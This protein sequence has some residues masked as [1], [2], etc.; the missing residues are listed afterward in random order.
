MARSAGSTFDGSLPV[1][2]KYHVGAINWGFVAGKTQ[3]W[4]PWD[5]WDHPY[6]R[7]QPVLW[8]HEVFRQ[9]DT[10]YRQAEVDLIRRLTQSSQSAPSPAATPSLPASPSAAPGTK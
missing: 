2:K 4:L 5:S 8:F 10:P 7:T 1:A 9:D 6:V 3:T